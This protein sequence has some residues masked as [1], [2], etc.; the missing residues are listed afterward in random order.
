LHDDLEAVRGELCKAII[1]ADEIL[2]GVLMALL[3]G[4]HVLL[5]SPPG[6]GKT[7]IVLAMADVLG[8]PLQRISFTPD[9]MPA[10]IIG[11]Y[12]VMEN[13]QGR[14]TF[15]FHQGPLFANLILA[16]HLN[17]GTPKT[18]SALLEAMESDAVSVS[19]E[20]FRLPQPF[21]V[22]AT[23]NP[24]EMEGTFPLP[25]PQLD[26]FTFKLH[27][28]RPGD[29]ALD[30]ILRQ[31]T[32]AEP[33][34]LRPIVDGRRI[35]EM[36]GLIRQLPVAPQ[37]RRRAIAIVQATHPDDQRAPASVRRFVRYGA[38]P[39]AARAIV[40][41]A[42]VR[43]VAAGRDELL[44]ADLAEVAPAALRHRLILNFEGQAENIEPEGLIA[45]ILSAVAA[46]GSL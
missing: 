29:E 5:E 30:A 33:A 37:V 15:E 41:G 43:A 34:R 44:A 9:L 20:K 35:L 1:G 24:L 6:L 21:F 10:D 8:L 25:E 26:R 40:L 45:E 12:V 38:S 42:K 2:D 17:R 32:E 13:P 31:T 23:Q 18:Q 11:T 16:D 39:R 3:A 4:G 22:L 19:N 46:T 28:A 36:R 27:L 7:A 14:R